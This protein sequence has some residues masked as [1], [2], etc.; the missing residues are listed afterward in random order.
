MM[1]SLLFEMYYI[2]YIIYWFFHIFKYKGLVVE[3][4]D[5]DVFFLVHFGAMLYSRYQL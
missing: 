1:S 3:Y 5:S 2:S 4:S